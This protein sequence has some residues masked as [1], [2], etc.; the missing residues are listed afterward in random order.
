MKVECEQCGR[1]FNKRPC[2]IKRDKH[3]F[4]S[5]ECYYEFNKNN[6]KIN[7]LTG[8]KFGRLTVMEYIGI[9]NHHSLWKCKCECG[10][11]K[12]VG[13]NYLITGR[14]KSCGC[15]QLESI[16][17]R[18][19]THGLSNERLYNIWKNMLRRCENETNARYA[20]YGGRGIYVCKEWHNIKV[21]VDWALKNGYADNLEID[22][23]N[24]D[25][26]YE[27]SNCK[28]STRREQTLNTRRNVK[29]TL[30]NETKTL[31][32]WA[33]QYGFNVNTIQY[34]Y[35]RGDRGERLFRPINHICNWR[36]KCIVK[37]V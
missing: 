11:E 27:P 19:I 15:Y 16:K 6:P 17:T 13:G 4:C 30:N 28:W 22:R 18:S 5:R 24:N 3:N 37:S 1:E 23:I 7:D 9:E 36:K 21:F 26:S 25:G 32:E 14:T 29:I 35:Y 31:T 12:V 2:F 34:R 10:N 8:K 20:D 33:E